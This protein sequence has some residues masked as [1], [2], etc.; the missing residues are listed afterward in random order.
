M[1]HYQVGFKS[2]MYFVI[3]WCTVFLTIGICSVMSNVHNLVHEASLNVNVGEQCKT[4]LEV[5]WI[6]LENVTSN[7]Q[8][9][10]QSEYLP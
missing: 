10:L 3:T 6:N 5:Y 2:E 4:S 7:A 9:A 8:W 1:L